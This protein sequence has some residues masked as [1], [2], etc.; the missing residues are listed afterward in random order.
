MACACKSTR[1]GTP[2]P[3]VVTMPGGQQKSFMSEITARAEVK[4]NPGAT[5]TPPAGASV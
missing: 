5:L 4:R 2:Q 1:N 3:W